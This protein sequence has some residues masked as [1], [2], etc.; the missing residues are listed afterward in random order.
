MGVP[1]QQGLLARGWRLSVI[2]GEDHGSLSV[3]FHDL[4][5]PFPYF[6]SIFY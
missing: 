2:G 3:H 1:P 4:V 5:F 6:F